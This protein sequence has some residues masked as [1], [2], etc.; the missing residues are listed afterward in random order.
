MDAPVPPFSWGENAKGQGFF[1]GL[2]VSGQ[3]FSHQQ[4]RPRKNSWP[5]VCWSA[6]IMGFRECLLKKYLYKNYQF[7][8]SIVIKY[9]IS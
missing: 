9:K 2:Q 6:C 4:K 5:P 1:L 3:H 7:I 8:L